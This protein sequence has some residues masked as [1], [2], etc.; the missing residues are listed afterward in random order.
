VGSRGEK[1][2]GAR[3]DILYVA[4]RD[5]PDD[6]RERILSTQRELL[7]SRGVLASVA[8]E[9]GVPLETLR[10]KVEV[11]GGL[12]DLLRITVGDPDPRRAL[13][14]VQVLTDRYLEVSGGLGEEQNTAR[15]LLER[16]IRSLTRRER[17]AEEGEAAQLRDRIGRLRD[18]V[19][20]LEVESLGVER[21]EVLS[22]PYVLSDPLSPKPLQAA[23]IG[24]L[25]GLALATATVV[26]LAR[27]G[28]G[29]RP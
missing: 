6:A 4:A 7:L 20:E 24:L 13:R 25:A 21:A 26:I 23:T 17:G 28:A 1:V 11:D 5:T 18:R 10:G 3:V 9:V 15:E 27:L 22:R 8:R 2:Y 14:Y 29:R 19:L 12:D 16:E